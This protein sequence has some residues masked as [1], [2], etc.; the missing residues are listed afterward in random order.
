MIQMD[1]K[2]CPSCWRCATLIEN[3]S[4]QGGAFFFQVS[5]MSRM[6]MNAKSIIKIV[7]KSWCKS[8]VLINTMKYPLCT[9]VFTL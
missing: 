1:L 6:D 3:P 2:E 5:M 9:K 8:S 7:P 4:C